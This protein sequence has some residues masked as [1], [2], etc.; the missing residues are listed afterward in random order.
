MKDTLLKPRIAHDCRAVNQ[1]KIGIDF[2]PVH[3]LLH[4]AVS[5]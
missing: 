2:G 3:S 5:L 4:N 1:C